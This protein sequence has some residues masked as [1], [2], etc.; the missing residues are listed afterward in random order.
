MNMNV[1]Y[2][3]LTDDALRQISKLDTEQNFDSGYG[4]FYG[5]PGNYFQNLTIL[6]DVRHSRLPLLNSKTATGRMA[7]LFDK[8]RF[9]TSIFEKMTDVELVCF[10]NVIERIY[11][12]QT[13]SDENLEYLL[14]NT[15][16]FNGYVANSFLHDV[17]FGEIPI[18]TSTND[19]LT[20][21][22]KNWVSFE[23]RT[24]E[25]S[26]R[27]HLWISLSA[28]R[29]EYPYTTITSVIP[30]C[31]PALLMNPALLVQNGILS[32]MQNSSSFIFK[33]INTEAIARDQNGV[34]TFKTKYN[35]NTSQNIQLPFALAYKGAKVPSNLEC[36][37]AIKKYLLDT[38]TALEEEI[39]NL[40]PEL[41]VENRFFVIPLWDMCSELTDRVVYNSIFKRKVIEEKIPRVFQTYDSS[42]L[43]MHM[44]YLLNSQNTML[45]LVIP[46]QLNVGYFSVLDQH[47][48]FVNYSTQ[49]AGF[50]FMDALTQEFAAKLSRCMAVLTEE[51][52]SG[53]FIT[54]EIDGLTYLTFSCGKSEYLLMNRAS[55]ETL[56]Q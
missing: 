9:D 30:P 38:T 39:E 4:S 35:V 46:D 5:E 10:L 40:F 43:N 34:Y 54:N 12:Q 24:A 42:F 55:Y 1:C 23:F 20:V 3:M 13:F 17:R 45:S 18:Y 50:R 11:L 49:S 56:V 48:T 16:T 8:D 28:F 21:P 26:F 25:T 36:R 32:F 51:T 14:Q 47:P 2:A 52:T 19:T 44:E 7:V 22:I 33:D 15:S 53:E 31:D 37:Q 27:I 41:F 6:H 29:A